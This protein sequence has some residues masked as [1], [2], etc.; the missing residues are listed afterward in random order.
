MV[1]KKIILP[2]ISL[3]LLVLVQSSFLPHF[4]IK[5]FAL[6]AALVFVILWNIFEPEKK[7][8]G[9]LYA[10]IGGI[11][12]DIF[13]SRPIGFNILLAGVSALFLKFIFRQY[14]R[15]PFFQKS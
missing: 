2:V 4:S 8:Y 11:F 9:I 7:Y 3:Y 10:L 15:F 6:N 1:I 5:G 14:V 12:L 13:S